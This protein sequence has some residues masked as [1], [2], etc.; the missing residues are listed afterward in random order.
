MKKQSRN[1]AKVRVGHQQPMQPPSRIA[2]H[3]A[4]LVA[5]SALTQPAA[6]AGGGYL[7]GRYW[8]ECRSGYNSELGKFSLCSASTQEYRLQYVSGIFVQGR[9]G[10]PVF[11]RSPGVDLSVAQNFHAQVCGVPQPGLSATQLM[12]IEAMRGLS[13]ALSRQYFY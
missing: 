13:E 7:S 6:H 2:L 1:G 11:Y 4:F 5:I 10:Y 12:G 3:A 9:C 8:N